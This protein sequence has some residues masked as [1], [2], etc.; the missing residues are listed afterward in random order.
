MRPSCLVTA[1]LAAA[2]LPVGIRTRME[3]PY[4][5]IA[6]HFQWL[7]ERIQASSEERVWVE[8]PEEVRETGYLSSLGKTYL[9][10]RIM[11]QRGIDVTGA[12]HR[13]SEFEAMRKDIMMRYAPVGVLVPSLPPKKPVSSAV[14]GSSQSS[15]F[16]KER[17]NGLSLFCEA[18]IQNPFLA[19]D[20]VWLDFMKASDGSPS[21]PPSSF[22]RSDRGGG[23][24]ILSALLD[25]VQSKHS[26]QQMMDR[27]IIIKDEVKL[28]EAGL[29]ALIEVQVRA[30]L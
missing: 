21:K 5:N 19:S 28:L 9:T 12:R 8:D 23:E 17:T 3:H 11:L 4:S 29:R 16:V 14:Y 27:V 1:T 10:Y 13:Y 7:D 6:N 18:I 22:D 26:L 24:L 30:E 2:H 20:V 15:V 25:S